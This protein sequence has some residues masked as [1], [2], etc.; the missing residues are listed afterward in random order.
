MKSGLRKVVK[1]VRGK[2]GT[3]RRSYWVADR[4]TSAKRLQR[5]LGTLGSAVGSRVGGSLGASGGGVIGGMAGLYSAA[6]RQQGMSEGTKTFGVALGAG[7]IAGYTG[8][9]IGGGVTGYYAGRNLGRRLNRR[10][11]SAKH[12]NAVGTFATVA[13]AAVHGHHLFAVARE[14]SRM[15]RDES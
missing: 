6:R 5:G 7:I 3:I 9:A 11:M 2:K 14:I 4:E 10:G 15:S 13:G 1:S 8:G 12:M